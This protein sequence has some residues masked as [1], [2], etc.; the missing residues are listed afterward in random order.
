MQL[1][2]ENEREEEKR[3]LNQKNLDLQGEIER[4]RKQIKVKKEAIQSVKDEIQ[5]LMQ[6][7]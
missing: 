2:A 3:K 7:L 6:D 4:M 5:S 1:R